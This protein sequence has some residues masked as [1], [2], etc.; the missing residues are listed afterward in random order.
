M[1]KFMLILVVAA[2]FAG[3]TSAQYKPTSGSVST[4]VQFNPFD[5]DGNTFSLDGVK[6]R[7]FI[8]EKN[9]LRVKLGLKMHSE[10]T[11]ENDSKDDFL[12]NKYGTFNLDLGYEYHF[13]LSKRVDLY[14]GASLGIA[15]YFASGKWEI[16]GIKGSSSN[17][18]YLLDSGGN[19][20]MRGAFGF[21]VS[22]FTGIDFYVYKGLY[23]GTELG[24]NITTIKNNQT[25]I[26]FDG[27]TTK[28][29]DSYRITSYGFDIQP[30]LRLGWTF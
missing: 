28:N 30:T 7:Y 27:R 18:T 17:T 16:D 8:N 1:K 5:N 13:G 11:K 21:G 14:A 10:T 12:T 25:E 24:L 6:V 22:I 9:A 20:E 23:V 29:K 2:L 4:E 19:N 3:N 15:K 26:D